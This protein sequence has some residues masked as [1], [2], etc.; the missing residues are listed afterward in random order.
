MIAHQLKSSSS[1]KRVIACLNI[2]QIPNAHL[3]L[4]E[5]ANQH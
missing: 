1:F 5:L 3:H 4:D 2:N